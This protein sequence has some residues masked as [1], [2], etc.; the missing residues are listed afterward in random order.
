MHDLAKLIAERIQA[1]LKRKTLTKCSI[2]AENC[3]VMARPFPGPWSFDHHP[4]LRGL[5]DSEA[6]M[7]IGQKSAQMGYTETALN[8]TFYKIDV[9]GI[10]CLYVLPAKTPDASDFSAARFDPALELSPHLSKIFSDVKN[11]GHKRAGTTNLYIRGSKARSGLKSVPVGFIVL[12]EVDEMEQDNIPLALERTSGQLEKQVWALST[13]TIDNYGIN[14]LYQLSTQEHFMFRC[15]ACGRSTELTQDCLVIT[16]TDLHDPKIKDSYYKCKECNVKLDQSTKASWLKDGFWEP[17]YSDRDARGFH[18]NQLY[19]CT[20]GPAD[21]ARSFLRS[22]RDPADEQE[23]YNSKLGLPHVVDGA[24]VTDADLDN[25]TSAHKNGTKGSGLITM[26]VDVGKW[27]HFEICQWQLAPIGS[28]DINVMSEARVLYSGKCLN[29]EELDALMRDYRVAM[30]VI[31]YNPERRKAYEFAMRNYGRVRLCEYTRGISGKQIQTNKEQQDPVIKVD[32]TSW[33]DMSLSRFRNHTIKIPQDTS[34]E[35]KT[36][37]KSLVRVYEKDA[38]KNP[39]GRYVCGSD[40]DHFGHSRNY[41][42]IALP[43]ACGINTSQN[44]SGVM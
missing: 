42:E 24:R 9:L 14:K 23:F 38:D 40:Q 39:V 33:L 17:T 10:D 22:Q 21:L 13:P 16:A 18:V 30:C 4:W 12:D 31:D 20:I 34:L 1:G 3:R 2:W 44:I 25:C 37:I 15:P 7:N 29:F 32:R 41:C 28:P 35:Y 27:L 26:G 11:I 6:E 36:H 43:L 19:S 8:I 5:H